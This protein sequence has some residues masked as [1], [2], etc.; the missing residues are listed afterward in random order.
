MSRFSHNFPQDWLLCSTL[1]WVQR[2][3]V[4]PAGK[5][6][7][8]S[9]LESRQKSPKKS[10]KVAPRFLPHPEVCVSHLSIDSSI[11]TEA[12]EGISHRRQGGADHRF[13]FLALNAEKN[14]LAITIVSPQKLDVFT[15]LERGGEK[16]DVVQ[17]SL[18]KFFGFVTS[19]LWSLEGS[20]RQ[21]EKS[22]RRSKLIS[23]HHH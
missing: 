13:F 1:C 11:R 8:Q 3:L 15:S 2:P 19:T 7:P 16:E 17:W 5:K 9:S 6:S 14:A 12:E 23:N 20:S 10:P 18:L 4:S 21:A 22:G